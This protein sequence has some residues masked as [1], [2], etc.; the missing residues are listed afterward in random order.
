M[1]MTLDQAMAVL[2]ST[3][4]MKRLHADAHRE[5]GNDYKRAA[6]ECNDPDLRRVQF[7]HSSARFAAAREEELLIAAIDIVLAACTGAK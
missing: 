4:E 2:Q 5:L 1:E 3:R 6:N 7:E